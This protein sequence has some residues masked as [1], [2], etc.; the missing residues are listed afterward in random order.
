V[1][2]KKGQSGN[3]RGNAD[4]KP[5]KTTRQLVRIIYGAAPEVLEKIASAAKAG[6]LE[7]QKIFVKLLPR[8]PRYVAT[9]TDFPPVT[10]AKEALA[11]IAD[12]L[13][14]VSRGEL[15]LDTFAALLDGLRHYTSTY[16]TAALETEV[17]RYRELQRGEG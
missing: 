10:S 8:L 16:Q 12:V 7:A 13:Q 11:Q 1:P 5:R 3:P 4:G 9:P 2:F 15:D 6:D 17:E 14:R